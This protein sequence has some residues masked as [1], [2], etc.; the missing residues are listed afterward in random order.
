MNVTAS[1]PM[2]TTASNG[3][4]A[5]ARWE[6]TCVFV[7]RDVGPPGDSSA[8]T[9]VDEDEVFRLIRADGTELSVPRQASAEELLQ[10]IRTTAAQ[11][12]PQADPVEA[13]LSDREM[14]VVKLIAVGYSN[15]E[16]AAKLVLS[17][18]TVETYK[19]RSFEKLGIR[20]RVDLVR[21]AAR[22]GWLMMI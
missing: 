12:A 2:P 4:C 21:Y 17:V 13:D 18:K 1:F 8:V 19:M 7:V 22:R 15:K 5:A 6:P 16:I 9:L 10:A 11:P 14:Q 3:K 20:S